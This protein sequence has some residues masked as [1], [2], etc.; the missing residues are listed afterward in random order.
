MVT[1]QQ[2][3]I[4]SESHISNCVTFQS[5]EGTWVNGMGGQ[6]SLQGFLVCYVKDK[7][8]DKDDSRVL[9]HST[10]GRIVNTEMKQIWVQQV[11][12]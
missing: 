8:G 7:E 11:L 1:D 6:L 10:E 12:D 2:I 4:F 3:F 9:V 5:C